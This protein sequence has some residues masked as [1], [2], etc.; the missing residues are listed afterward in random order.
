MHC[1]FFEQGA[2]VL[3]RKSDEALKKTMEDLMKKLGQISR[4]PR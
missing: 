4:K 2:K 3:T 1:H